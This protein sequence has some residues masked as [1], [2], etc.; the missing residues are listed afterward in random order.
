MTESIKNQ[1]LTIT[2]YE[3]VKIS[4]YTVYSSFFKHIYVYIFFIT[5]RMCVKNQIFPS[6]NKNKH[7]RCLLVKA[8]R[9]TK[10]ISL[11]IPIIDTTYINSYAIYVRGVIEVLPDQ[12]QHVV[13]YTGGGDL[14][15]GRRLS[16]SQLREKCWTQKFLKWSISPDFISENG[17]QPPF[18]YFI[19]SKL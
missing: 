2:H 13:L 5:I 8:M 3:E 1:L 9:Q 14:L 18:F 12:G 7:F 17:D 15:Q 6:N 4:L 10:Y 11:L 19:W 16:Q